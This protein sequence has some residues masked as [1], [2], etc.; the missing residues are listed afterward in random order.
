MEYGELMSNWTFP[1]GI[2]RQQYNLSAPLLEWMKDNA[3]EWIGM[4]AIKKGFRT[5]DPEA[6]HK[7]RPSSDSLYQALRGLVKSKH[8]EKK[9]GSEKIKSDISGGWTTKKQY[10]NYYRIKMEENR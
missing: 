7:V 4:R 6:G 2:K 3:F 9:P 1:A 10:M 5:I 8:L